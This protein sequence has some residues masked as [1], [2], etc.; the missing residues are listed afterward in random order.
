MTSRL[1]KNAYASP[2]IV[3]Q[4]RQFNC[5]CSPT[6]RLS[7]AMRL[8]VPARRWSEV[9]SR[10]IAGIQDQ[11]QFT[12]CLR[13]LRFAESIDS[14][15]DERAWLGANLVSRAR[16]GNKAAG[17]ASLVRSGA[18]R[19]PRSSTCIVCEA[20]QTLAR[21]PNP[22]QPAAPRLHQ[23]RRTE[24]PRFVRGTGPVN[25]VR[26]TFRPNWRVAPGAGGGP[27]IDV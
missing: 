11:R 18:L 24:A 25:G 4:T 5:R 16:C 8:H 1:G 26:V 13:R 17:S 21:Y 20:S 14:P 3:R 19:T 23:S 27:S 7:T 2:V 22:R 15:A 12:T 6:M 9:D 10:T